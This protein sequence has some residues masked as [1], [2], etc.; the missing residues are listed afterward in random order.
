MIIA[1]NEKMVDL[2]A[3][4]KVR[5]SIKEDGALKTKLVETTVG[6]VLFNHTVPESVGFINELLTKKALREII[7]KIL[8]QTDIPST[9]QFLDDMKDLGYAHAFR[10]GLSFSLEDIRIP[11]EKELLIEV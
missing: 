11:D 6:R 8:R 3:V 1:L 4:I 2:H 10:G 9:A 5:T 7:S